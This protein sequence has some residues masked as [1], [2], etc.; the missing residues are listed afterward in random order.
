[1]GGYVHVLRIMDI[2]LWLHSLASPPSLTVNTCPSWKA[3]ICPQRTKPENREMLYVAERLR[4]GI[5]AQLH[6]IYFLKAFNHVSHPPPM[7]HKWAPGTQGVSSEG[8]QS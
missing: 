3:D 2:H 4:L 1:M 7:K 6:L 8:R 5:V